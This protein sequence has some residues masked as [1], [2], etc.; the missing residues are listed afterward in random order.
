LSNR[1]LHFFL[2][3]R[4]YSEDICGTFFAV[5]LKQ[6][7]CKNPF[8]VLHLLFR[9]FGVLKVRPLCSATLSMDLYT[10]PSMLVTFAD[11]SN[12]KGALRKDQQMNQKLKGDKP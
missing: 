9:L 7:A 11:S 3:Y 10:M 8:E 2:T 5:F 1:N 12:R 4:Y 6:A